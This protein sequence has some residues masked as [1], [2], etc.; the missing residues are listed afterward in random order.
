MRMT[1][2][3]PKH[4]RRRQQLWQPQELQKQQLRDETNET[5]DDE[6]MSDPEPRDRD[7]DQ[8]TTN[9]RSANGHNERTESRGPTR[10]TQHRTR[11]MFCRQQMPACQ[12]PEHEETKK[13]SKRLWKT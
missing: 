1:N 11:R 4:P 3:D 13:D 6:Q 8:T 9:T 2:D 5:T 10:Y 7:D 12:W